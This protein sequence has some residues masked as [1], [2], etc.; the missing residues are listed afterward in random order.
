[1]HS[2]HSDY[3]VDFF[4]RDRVVDSGNLS[5]AGG[6][7][8]RAPRNKKKVA[9]A[10]E[11]VSSTS[12]ALSNESGVLARFSALQETLELSVPQLHITFGIG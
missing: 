10:I 1:L 8:V 11:V 5:I 7:L 12:T 3:S 9:A 4:Y 2:I 6:E